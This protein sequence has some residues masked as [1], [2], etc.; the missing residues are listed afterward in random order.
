[1][2]TSFEKIFV[3]LKNRFKS[4]PYS[5]ISLGP[6]CYPRTILSRN[7][8]IK[9]KME[10]QI[11][12]PFDLAWFHS[13]K[14][15]TEFLSN[16]F[17]NFLSDLRYSQYSGSWDNGVKINFSHEA[18]IGPNEKNKL[19]KIYKKRIN[20]FNKA[21]KNNKPIVFIQIFKDEKVGQDC[22]NT[23]NVLKNLCSHKNF[24]YI[25]I[26]C[27]GCLKDIILSRN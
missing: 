18:Y 12:Y 2:N 10:G 14:Y 3:H 21:L 23:Y 22:I 4:V 27:A 19:I 16:N 24:I 17:N 25:V 15:V 20:N 26:D 7:K 8:L 11:S 9:T 13:A 1:M 6:N 5:I